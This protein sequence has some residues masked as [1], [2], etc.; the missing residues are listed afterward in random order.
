VNVS[1]KRSGGIFYAFTTTQLD[2]II[3]QKH[4]IAAKLM[5]TNLKRHPRAGGR[6]F[7]D[8]RDALFAQLLIVS[9]ISIRFQPYRFVDKLF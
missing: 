9:G 6:F 1:G 8:Q 3:T 2:I 7:K 4:W 5:H